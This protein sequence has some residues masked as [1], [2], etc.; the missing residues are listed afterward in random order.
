MIVMTK[1]PMADLQKE[2]GVSLAKHGL[3]A[4]GKGGIKVRLVLDHSW[5]MKNW[6]AAGAVQRLTE[7]VLGLAS[8]LDD[9]GIIEVWYFG[10]GVSEVYQVSLNRASLTQNMPVT[11]AAAPARRRG[12]F[13]RRIPASAPGAPVLDPYYVGWVNR[14]HVLE[15]WGSTNYPAGLRAP[16]DF[17][18]AEGD[19]DPALVIFQTDGGP[20]DRD[21]A[22]ATLRAVSGEDTFFAF[23]VFGDEDE[24]GPHSAATYMKGLDN[25]SG[26]TRDNASVLFTG[27]LDRFATL[28]DS[29]VYDGVL[30]E[31]V[32]QWLPQV[33]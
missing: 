13:G 3:H 10:S 17:A 16:V 1:T 14:S 28:P 15:P 12:L 32:G 22:N 20:D 8:K 23:V 9:D 29:A 30:K 6:Y 19:E 31:F 21:A 5:S 27:G 33:L 18:R 25:L 4:D 24:T 11:G 7:Q 2:A 26:R